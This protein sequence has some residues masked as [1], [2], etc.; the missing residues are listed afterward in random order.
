MK[1]TKEYILEKAFALFLDKGYD[2]VSITDLQD[3]LGMGRASIYHHF[4]SKREL[5]TEVI[6]KCYIAMGKHR[7]F[8]FSC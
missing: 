5:F 8:W 3:E 6:D 7:T 1:N 2:G 4:K